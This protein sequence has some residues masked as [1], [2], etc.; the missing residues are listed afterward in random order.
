MLSV[1]EQKLGPRD[2]IK[3]T[4][5]E[6]EKNTQ[7]AISHKEGDKTQNFLTKNQE[8][9]DIESERYCSERS[10]VGSMERPDGKSVTWV[11]SLLVDSGATAHII[12]DLNNFIEFDANHDPE[13]H[14]IELA[15]GSRVTGTVRG[16][17]KAKFNFEDTNGK[18][19]DIT[20]ENALY[21]PSYTQNIFSVQAATK[22][23]ATLS[24]SKTDSK[25]ETGTGTVFKIEEKVICFT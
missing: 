3:T 5:V 9:S 21:I 8:G 12:C 20:L 23:G 4:I 14:V 16:K 7:N 22:K 17:G 2:C 6:H 13:N 10:K 19:C 24:F 15:D 11:N 18:D 1:A 25:M